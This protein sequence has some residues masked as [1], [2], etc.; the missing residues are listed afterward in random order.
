MPSWNYQLGYDYSNNKW[1]TTSVPS[2]AEFFID[3]VGVSTHR[4]AFRWGAP[5]GSIH[6]ATAQRD[7]FVRLGWTNDVAIFNFHEGNN[8]VADF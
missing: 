8:L 6:P 3:S 1:N 5:L 7:R 2:F 4:F